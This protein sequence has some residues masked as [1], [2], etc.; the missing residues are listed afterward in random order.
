MITESGIVLNGDLSDIQISVWGFSIRL[1][2]YSLCPYLI[3]QWIQM[4][5]YE[6]VDFCWIFVW[7]GV[8]KRI[9]SR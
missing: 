5:I 7:G 1:S 4:Q 8:E 3:F 2:L 9:V 6:E